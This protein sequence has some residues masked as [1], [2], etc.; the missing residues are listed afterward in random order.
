MVL[1]AYSCARLRMLRLAWRRRPRRGVP[2]YGSR[3][4]IIL[5]GSLTT[6]DHGDI[7]Q[8]IE[9]LRRDKIRCSIVSIGAE[10]FILKHI[11]AQTEG[12]YTVAL[13]DQHFLDLLLAHCPPPP[14]PE[15]NG[16]SLSLSH[17]L[18][19]IPLFW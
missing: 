10:V 7:F 16:L 13:D 2:W 4:L 3:E 1:A 9:E 19:F 17:D 15:S 8:T 18:P 5:Y 6:R 12:S 14:C 11:A